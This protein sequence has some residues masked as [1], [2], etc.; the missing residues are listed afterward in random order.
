MK[1]PIIQVAGIRSLDEAA[2]LVEA[3]FSHL[4]FP[5]A[6]NYHA[7]D[8][9]IKAAADIIRS[10]PASVA[11]VLITY[12]NKAKEIDQL[13]QE[14]GC[15]IVQ[16]HGAI[17][18]DELE[19]LRKIRP[20]IEIWKSLVINPQY[21]EKVFTEFAQYYPLAD[22]FIT[23]T[24]DPANGASGAT[25]KTHDWRISAKLVRQSDKAIILAGGLNAGNVYDATIQTQVAGVDVHTGIE[26]SRGCKVKEKAEAFVKAAL[27]AFDSLA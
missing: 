9:T 10:L 14:L 19:Q 20:D 3:G 22:A 17:D 18:L 6:L 23:D 26:D 5:F 15:R 21:A 25:G 1:T 16:V 24:Y 7:E 12:L 27:K 8:T 11:V 2:M 4:G 13:M